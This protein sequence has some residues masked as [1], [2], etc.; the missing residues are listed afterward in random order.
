M[1]EQPIDKTSIVEVENCGGDVSP[2]QEKATDA[3]HD[4]RIRHVKSKEERRLVLEQ[5][6]LILP[7]LSGGLFS[8]F[9]DRDQI[10]NARVMGM[11]V[12]LGLT[13]QQFYNCIM[14]FSVLFGVFACAMVSAKSYAPVMV[15]RVLIGLAEAFV[16][17]AYLYISLWYRPDELSLRTAAIY[18]MSPVAGAISGI[19]AYELQKNVD[20]DLGL[21]AWQWL[22]IVEG[23]ITIFFAMTMVALLPALPD[24]VAE[25]GSLIFGPRMSAGLSLQDFERVRQNTHDRRPR[26]HQILVALK[27][28]KLYLGSAMVGCQGIGIGA[29]S[30]FLPTFIKEF[31]FSALDTQFYTMT[32]YAFGLATLVSISFLSDRL[33]RKAWVAFGCHCIT[34]IGFVILLTTTN[35]IALLAGA[36]F[37]LAGAYPGLVGFTKRATAAWFSQIFIQSESIIA[38]QVYDSPPCFFKGHGVALGFYVLAVTCTMLLLVMATKANAARDQRAREFEERGQ[39]DEEALKTIEDLCDFHP[40]Y[41]YAL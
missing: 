26:Y 28:P 5:D 35:K 11:Q 2:G 16:K 6:L 22:F 24:T 18:G 17:N 32:P 25:E 14:M 33:N 13:S 41:R 8:G 10:G 34:M 31:G 37:V 40:Q 12:D 4:I 29:F 19:I 1:S 23:A 15:L 38:T 7:L 3:H 20:G 39:L 9:L 30:V 21:H 27:D 36:C